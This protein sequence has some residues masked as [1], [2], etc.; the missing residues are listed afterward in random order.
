MKDDDIEILIITSNISL[1][2][3]E[4]E[5]YTEDGRRWLEWTTTAAFSGRSLGP[6]TYNRL[7]Y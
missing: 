7:H 6:V 1:T 4:S 3:E 5:L 2:L